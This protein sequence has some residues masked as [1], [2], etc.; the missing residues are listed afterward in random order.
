[1]YDSSTCTFTWSLYVAKNLGSRN[2]LVAYRSDFA[3]IAGIYLTQGKSITF[4]KISL[5][6]TQ[7]RSK[8]FSQTV[9]SFINDIIYE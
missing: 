5:T 3:S 7:I 9:Y 2:V 4:Y 6:G 1:M 8:Y